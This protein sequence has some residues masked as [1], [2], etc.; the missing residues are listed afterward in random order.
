MLPNR[1]EFFEITWGCQLSGLYYS[2]VNTHFTPDEVAYVIG[3]SDAKAVFID[4]S[5]AELGERILE[6]NDGVDVHIS[7]GGA[8]PGW[9]PYDDALAE[10]DAAP[11][12]SD[13]SEMLYSSGTTGRPKAVRR[14]LPDGRP[15]VVG[16][17]G[18]GVLAG[19][20]L[21]HDPVERV[22][23]SGAAVPRR[24]HQLHDGGPPGGRRLD[25]DAASSTPR[26]CCA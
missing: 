19:A 14:P 17:E 5:M 16:A 25:P 12:I 24:G 15:G 11:P 21:R 22:S 20:A 10:S 23:V 6:V 13:G 26:P 18:A 4:A 1:P 3:D 9:R 8:L 7:V 2:A